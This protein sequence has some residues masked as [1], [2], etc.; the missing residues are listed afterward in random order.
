M[1]FLIKSIK[2]CNIYVECQI[3]L[4]FKM[5]KEVYNYTL[6]KTLTRVQNINLLTFLTLPSKNIIKYNYKIIND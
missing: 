6:R 4:I 2:S 1:S 3:K 5:S